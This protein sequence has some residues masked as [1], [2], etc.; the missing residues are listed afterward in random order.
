MVLSDILLNITLLA[1]SDPD[2]NYDYGFFDKIPDMKEQMEYLV[3]S[4][5]K[6]YEMVSGLSDKVPAMANNFLTIKS[7]LEGMLENPYSIARKVGD[8]TSSQESLSTW[9]LSLQSIPLLIDY[10]DIGNPEETWKSVSSNPFQK[11]GTTWKLFISSFFKDYDNVG[12]VLG[13]DVEIK[14]TINVWIA[15]GTEWAEVIKEMADED[16]TPE[17]GRAS[18][19]ERV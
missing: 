1:G 5:Q 3:E 18:C 6:K 17:I 12:S 13:D 10:F 8:L 4:M 19:R 16:F 2:P 7:Q 9:Y 11:M 14:E 15:R